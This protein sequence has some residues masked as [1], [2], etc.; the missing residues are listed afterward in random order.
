M[1]EYQASREL[2]EARKLADAVAQIQKLEQLAAQIGSATGLWQGVQDGCSQVVATAEQISTRMSAETK[3]FMEF[4]QKAN[5]SERAALR[6]EVDKLRRAEGD[7]LQLLVRVLDHVLGLHSAAV[8]S[9]QPQ[10][11][12]QLT[13]FRDAVLDLTRRI[14]LVPYG[15]APGQPFDAA[16]HQRLDDK[17]ELPPE[18]KVAE[19]LAPGYTFQ[20]QTL[21][22]TLVRLE[23]ETLPQASGA[24]GAS[25]VPRAE[26]PGTEVAA[27]AGGLFSSP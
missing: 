19:T 27:Q 10:V 20:G 22:R 14:G 26:P 11:V 8:R 17:A 23:G 21:R 1:L 9:G 24:Q 6:L 13:H 15:A 16:A 25:A 12:K 3:G 5:D 7:W 18:A 4:M 2:V